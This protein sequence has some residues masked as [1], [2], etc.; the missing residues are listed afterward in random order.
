MILNDIDSLMESLATSVASNGNA[1][2][3]F[4]ARVVVMSKF[5]DATFPQLTA[6]QCVEIIRQFRQG[7]EDSLSLMDDMPLPG[8]YHSTLLEQ[9]NN[10]LTA[11]DRKSGGHR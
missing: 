11:L 3:R 2:S 4:G 5:I 10:L 8:E 9:T 1:V 6:T 7:I